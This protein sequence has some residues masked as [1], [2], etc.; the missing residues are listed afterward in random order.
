MG[1]VLAGGDAERAHDKSVLPGRRGGEDVAVDA[2]DRTGGGHHRD[3]AAIILIVRG[4]HDA[5]NVVD[6]QPR[7]VQR[8]L[9]HVVEQFLQGTPVA[10]DTGQDGDADDPGAVQ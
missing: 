1:A 3:R 5:V 10:A 2:A 8:L 6:V 7:I 9:R 4:D